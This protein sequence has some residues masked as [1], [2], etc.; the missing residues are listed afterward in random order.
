[1][2]VHYLEGS[3]TATPASIYNSV[4]A[5][6]TRP[7]NI[8]T[9]FCRATAGRNLSQLLYFVFYCILNAG[10]PPASTLSCILNLSGTQHASFCTG[11]KTASSLQIQMIH[12]LFHTPNK[13]T[14]SQKA[15]ASPDRLLSIAHCTQLTSSSTYIPFLTKEEDLLPT[16]NSFLFRPYRNMYSVDAQARMPRGST[17]TSSQIVSRPTT[18]ANSNL[19]QS[20]IFLAVELAHCTTLCPT[21]QPGE[22]LLVQLQ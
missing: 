18:P 22:V 6:T 12:D 21:D 13:S 10:S 4:S 20:G 9:S 1:M 14:A 8:V 15:I 3:S 16:A 5:L 17:S 2:T 19:R 11:I 7:Q